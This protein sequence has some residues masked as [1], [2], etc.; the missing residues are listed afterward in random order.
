MVNNY[1]DAETDVSAGKRTLVVRFGRRF[2]RAQFVAAHALGLA[3]IF[4]LGADDWNPFVLAGALG[5][6]G[7]VGWR[8][9][10]RLA[11]ATTPAELIRLLGATGLYLAGYA[12]IV[13]I[14]LIWG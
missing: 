13:S 12:F 2:A 1:R 3:A 11:R 6:C 10:C 5:L 14:G 7:A 4:A 8:Q 9:T